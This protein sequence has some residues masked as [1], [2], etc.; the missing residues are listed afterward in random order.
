MGVQE[1]IMGARFGQHFLTDQDVV[2]DILQQFQ[3]IGPVIEVGPGKGALTHFLLQR[4]NPLMV[5]EID[6]ALQYF[7]QKRAESVSNLHV[8]ACDVLSFDWNELESWLP[9]PFA[10]ISNLPYEISGPFLIRLAKH[11]HLWSEAVLMLQL[12]IVSKVIAMPGSH[13]YGRLSVQMQRHCYL[14]PGRIVL[15]DSFSPPPRVYSQL[16]SLKPRTDVA[17]VNCELVWDVMLREAFCH[18]RQMIRR[19]FRDQNVDWVSI[20][21]DGTMRPE[22]L[23]VSAWV[24][25]ANVLNEQS[26]N[27]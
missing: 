18:R 22:N 10:I 19:T 12:E 8:K 13:D 3:P 5:I 14:D 11:T 20:G 21:L 17:V 7:W 2:S 16:L 25:L 27:R 4:P 26:L 23:D 24:R 15:P 9:S 6:T 1:Q